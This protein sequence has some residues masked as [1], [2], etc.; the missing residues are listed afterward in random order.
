MA[1]P[2]F[3]SLPS[4]RNRRCDPRSNHTSRERAAALT[5]QLLT[6]SRRQLIQPKNWTL[7]KSRQK[8]DRPF[9]TTFG[10]GRV[11]AIKLLSVASHGGG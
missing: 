10:R 1:M 11:V 3:W 7:I 8:H 2:R 5:R 9:G 4:W 6:F